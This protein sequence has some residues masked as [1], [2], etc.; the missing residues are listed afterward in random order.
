MSIPT[1]KQAIRAMCRHCLCLKKGQPGYDCL[2]KT[3]PLH[4]GMPFRGMHPTRKV[5]PQGTPSH[6]DERMKALALS[7]PPRRPTKR[8][9]RDQCMMCIPDEYVDG[10][11]VDCTAQH[12]PLWP[13]RPM[14]PGGTPRHPTRVRQAAERNTPQGFRPAVSEQR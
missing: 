13:F 9:I 6:E 8:M 7:H 11:L 14:Q 10:K 4:A 1:P 5:Q 2:G 12:C 3:C